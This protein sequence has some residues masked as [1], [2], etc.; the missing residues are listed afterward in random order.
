MQHDRGLSA[1]ALYPAKDRSMRIAVIG[2][3]I[4]GNA[5]AWALSARH[6]VTLYE[7][8][9]RTGG[10]SATVDID[11]DGTQV[12]VDTGFIV[13]NDL[14]YP[15]LVAL[16]DHLEVETTSSDMS[17]AVSIGEGALE[18]SG[19]SLATVFA[20]KRNLARPRFLWMLREVLRFNRCCVADLEAGR[21]DGLSLGQ[22]LEQ[23]R[24]G[25]GFIEDYLVPMGA[26]I[27]STPDADL[28]AFPATNFVRFFRNHRLIDTERPLWRT[29]A[30]GSRNY[31]DRLL[32]PL[33]AA[34]RVRVSSPVVAVDRHPDHVEIRT[35]TGDVDHFDQVVFASHTDQTLA[36]LSAPSPAERQI[37][38]AIRYLPN[39]VVLHRDPRMMPRRN[40][41]WASWNYL[42][43]D[44]YDAHRPVAVTYWMN[45]LQ[46]IPED[47]PL[48][49]TLN[50]AEQPDEKLVFGRWEFDHPQFDGAAIAAQGRLGEIQGR[51]RSWFCGA[52]TGYGF[53][54][55]G[56][57][58]GLSVAEALGGVIPWR[59]PARPLV[60]PVLAEAAE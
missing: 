54:E 41:V 16:F 35:A 13:Y 40:A 25:R 18:W 48:F 46:N 4:S 3:G 14:N 2:S 7:R 39:D 55:D 27:W 6:D 38:G 24:Y 42:R 29:V 44:G 32:A 8:R 31:V 56:L 53:H 12:P 43:R 33:K 10:H 11:Y 36:M 52:W 20:Q 22:Y 50:P 1:L 34:G 26:A 45:R 17:F 28:L 15:N 57:S 47:M 60:E 30:G 19:T 59:V 5:C 9:P 51:N 21:L 37:L 23:G 58:S 49:V